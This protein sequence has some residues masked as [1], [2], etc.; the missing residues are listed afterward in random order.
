L[1]GAAAILVM[2]SAKADFRQEIW[3]ADKTPSI[4]EQLA[5]WVDKSSAV[6]NSLSTATGLNDA[7]V[8]TIHRFDLVHIFSHVV[9]LTPENIPYYGGESYGYLLYGWIPRAIWPD[10]PLAMEANIMFALDYGLLMESQRDTTRMGVGFLTEAYANFGVWGVL[11]VMFLIGCLF[12][13]AGTVFNG[14]QSDGGK[15]VYIAVLVF[16]LNGM[17]SSTTMFFFFGIQG[18]VVVP[19]LLRYYAKSWRAPD[20]VWPSAASAPERPAAHI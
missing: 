2:N 8:R 16:Y 11:G 12:G 17:G 1:L 9:E 13:V 10:K 4:P 5:V 14:P 20:C 15:A 19:L 3:L 7:V 6:V 18:F